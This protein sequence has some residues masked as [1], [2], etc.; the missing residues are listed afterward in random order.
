VVEEACSQVS[1]DHP[2]SAETHSAADNTVANSSSDS[3]FLENYSRFEANLHDDT[4]AHHRDTHPC[5]CGIDTHQE[6]AAD[7]PHHTE[8]CPALS[9]LI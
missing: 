5:L 4:A 3:S 1:D 6:N 9:L 2:H 8:I 7:I